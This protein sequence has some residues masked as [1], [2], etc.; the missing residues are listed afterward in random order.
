VPTRGRSRFGVYHAERVPVG[1]SGENIEADAVGGSW[2]SLSENRRVWATQ[3]PPLKLL[4]VG[5]ESCEGESV[6]FSPSQKLNL[7]A[8]PSAGFLFLAHYFLGKVYAVTQGLP[9]N[10]QFPERLCGK[11]TGVDKDQGAV[12][13][14]RISNEG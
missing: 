11:M 3:I 7:E 2:F 10:R 14:S 9:E 6:K 4:A 13:F 12:R 8:R 1:Q 5:A